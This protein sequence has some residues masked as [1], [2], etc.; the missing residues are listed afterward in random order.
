MGRLQGKVA[1][2]TGASSGIG[3]ACALRFAAEG[4][5]IAGFDVAEPAEEH[6]TK[7]AAS[8]PRA[9]FQQVDVRDEAAVETAVARVAERFGRIDVLVNAAGVSTAG[10]VDAVDA[11]E[12]DR[13]LDINLKGTFLVSK[14]VVRGMMERHS[15]S[16]IHLASVEGLEGVQQQAAYNAS[17]GGVVLLTRNM[18]VD[19]GHLG[20]RVNC[21]CPGLIETPMTS[22]LWMD[23]LREIRDRFIDLH[24][25]KR[26]GRPEE[27]AAAAL[28]LASDEASFVTGHALVVD[29]GFSAGRRLMDPW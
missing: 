19:Y 9:D 13:V 26:A 18:A 17:K 28:F 8:A 10:A 3:G 24:M 5:S 27:V 11:A 21:L 29:G 23:E 15:G 20:I 4:A 25:L 22:M 16:I 14:H 1:L 12:W 6:W 2:I 7:I